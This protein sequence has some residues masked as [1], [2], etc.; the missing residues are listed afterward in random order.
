M[1]FYRKKD[2][3]LNL[4]RLPTSIDHAGMSRAIPAGADLDPA[5]RVAI[6]EYLDQSP[7]PAAG[8]QLGIVATWDEVA[9]TVTMDVVAIPAVP[10]A[11]IR[12]DA[13]MQIK[14]IRGYTLD[15][16][17]KT[18]SGVLMVYDSNVV[19]AR[20]YLAGDTTLLRT[21][22]MPEQHLA[23]GLNYGMDATQFANYI[24]AENV[25]LGPSSWDVEDRYGA[26]L[27]LAYYA[28]IAYV[29]PA[30]EEYR[31]WCAT[32]SGD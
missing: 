14:E 10:E 18:K 28:P 3:P 15:K 32:V 2:N 19:A 13:A 12:T 20:A 29:M 9:G 1:N 8:F 17:T 26:A 16:F 31:E 11:A 22:M 6:G 5:Y 21:G 27:M 23:L 7:I 24:L 4:H 25:R 30:V